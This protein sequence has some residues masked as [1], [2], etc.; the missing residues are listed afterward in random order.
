MT[1]GE[2]IGIAKEY[3]GPNASTILDR[4]RRSYTGGYL[5]LQQGLIWTLA[6]P[7]ELVG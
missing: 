6:I 5:H 4:G 2:N 7:E 1:T 3:R